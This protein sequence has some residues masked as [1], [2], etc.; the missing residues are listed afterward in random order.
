MSASA[1]AATMLQ[2]IVAEAVALTTNQAKFAANSESVQVMLQAMIGGVAIAAQTM[3]P[4]MIIVGGAAGEEEIGLKV[5]PR[6]KVRPG[7]QAFPGQV[8]ACPGAFP[9]SS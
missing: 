3:P 9:P 8:K 4:E 7:S 1:V 6:T 5:V 2:A